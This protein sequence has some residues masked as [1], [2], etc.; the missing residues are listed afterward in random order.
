MK[1]REE[2]VQDLL[3]E[4]N[5]YSKLVKEYEGSIAALD[6]ADELYQQGVRVSVIRKILK[7]DY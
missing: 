2:A 6:K 1:T 4:D 3:E 7:E 5:R